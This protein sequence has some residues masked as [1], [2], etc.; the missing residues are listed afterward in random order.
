MN[1]IPFG[2]KVDKW[3]MNFI[4]Y[5]SN[6]WWWI[7]NTGCSRN[8]P[9]E[10]LMEENIKDSI[11]GPRGRGWRKIFNTTFYPKDGGF[12]DLSLGLRCCTCV[13]P[14]GHASKQVQWKM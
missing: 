3:C 1:F 13:D 6:E 4:I 2:L 9:L 14:T 7:V 11:I 5:R 8:E 10:G 12:H